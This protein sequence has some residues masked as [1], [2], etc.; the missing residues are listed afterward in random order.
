MKNRD[1]F[2]VSVTDNPFAGKKHICIFDLIV[3][4]NAFRLDIHEGEEN[5]SGRDKE[6][7]LFILKQIEHGLSHLQFIEA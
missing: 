6:V 1:K 5:F 4:L 3:Y 7:A 2:L